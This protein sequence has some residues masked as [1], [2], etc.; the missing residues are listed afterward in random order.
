MN[1]QIKVYIGDVKRLVGTLF[2]NASG[3]RESSGLEYSPEWIESSKSF[4]IDPALP[5]GHGRTFRSKKEGSSVFHGAIADSEPD[6]W[7]R[8][9]ILRA[10]GK[11]RKEKKD[12]GIS[13]DDSRVDFS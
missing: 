3:N 4:E 10:N 9:V 11:H 6:G 13:I 12:R 5:L 2:F 8:Q 7:A 1:R